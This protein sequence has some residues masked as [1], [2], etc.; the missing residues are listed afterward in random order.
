MN[1]KI[2][3]FYPIVTSNFSYNKMKEDI[4]QLI[5]DL[6]NDSLAP[7]ETLEPGIRYDSSKTVAAKARNRISQL[8]LE[9]AHELK[10]IIINEKNRDRKNE[11]Y[12][13][14]SRI[15]EKH[16]EAELIHFLIECLSSEKN[17]SFI[18]LNLSGIY[19]AGLRLKAHVGIILD[20][21][22]SK[23]SHIR[24][25]AIQILALYDSDSEKIEDFLVEMLNNSKDE[26][27]L[28]Y[29]N[30][31]LISQGTQKS[32][33]PLKRVIRESNK[34]DVLSTGICALG[35]IDGT[36]QVDFFLEM[37]KEKKNTF[38]K[39]ILTEFI[40]KHANSGAIDIIVD[41][42]KKILSR[43]RSTNIHYGEG[44]HPELVHALMYLNQFEDEDARIPKLKKWILEKKMDFLDE[45][46]SNWV[47][48]NLKI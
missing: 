32:I 43:K 6:L 20:F 41:R 28:L 19:F 45:T 13:I 38:V 24:H 14:L 27:D 36:N 18:G 7:G 30:S 5:T 31:S 48:E 26:Y 25:S 39:S 10:E 11:A 44:Q 3:D 2:S 12:T 35:K 22:Q 29:T 23:N 16:N 1:D 37:M 17:K 9:C 33:E 46:E 15:A 8:D 4:N 40:C 47:N 21:A 34:Q 42:V